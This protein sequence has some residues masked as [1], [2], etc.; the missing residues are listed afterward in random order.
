MS[1]G[2][3]SN[4]RIVLLGLGVI[5]SF[6]CVGARLV[7]LHVI[8]RDKLV[9][10]V[11]RARRQIT[12]ETARRGDIL[13]T[14]GDTLATSRSLIV[15]GVDPQALRKE[16]EAKWPKLAAMLNLS[17]ADLT[18][19]F[20]DKTRAA[21]PDDKS[22]EDRLIRWAKL[23]DDVEES[24]YDQINKLDI[25][26]VYGNRTYRRA[27]PHNSMA[28]HLI[29]FVNKEGQ[30]A[31]G[32]E[33][34]ADFY[35]RGQ[36]GWCETEKDGLRRE[37]AQFRSREVDATPGYSVVLSIDSAVQ[38]IVEQEIDAIV[39]KFNPAKVSVI[40]SDPNSGFILAMA[41]YPTF[42]LNEYNTL[43][44]D[45]MGNMRNLAITDILDP[46]STFKS[47]T[48]S[49]ALNE[50][51][52]TPATRFNCTL[53]SMDYKGTP[54]KFMPDDHHFDHPLTV[55]EIVSHSSNVG[56]AQLGMLLGEDRLY[57]YARSF[58]FG[59][60]SGFPFGGE[61]NGI[62]NSPDK[63]RG[64]DITHIPAG[65]SISATPLQIH[66]AMATIA[67]GG[68]LMRPQLIRQVR[69]ASGEVVYNFT[70]SVRRHVVTTRTAEQTA[71]LL[72]G[73]VSAEGTAPGAAIPNFE[74]AGKTGTSQ[75]LINGRYSDHDHVG[76]F[77]GFFPASR[78]RVVISV[79]VS[80]AKPPNGRIAYGSV[81]AAPSF[82]HIGE[83]LIQYLDIKP[84]TEQGSNLLV[85]DGGRR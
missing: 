3:A 78:P 38:H 66:Y 67:N 29:G 54:R 35:L 81:V 5:A 24:T 40:V 28:A 22:D 27:Y 72:E 8:D 6:G 47:V 9:S 56:A 76:S 11:D 83:Q 21:A 13:D 39:K 59:E 74:V 57:N 41:N 65:Y 19:V 10:Y 50:G 7:D 12:V 30:A 33:S 45:E 43:G 25:K 48:V 4:Y 55:A 49:A 42:N 18:K 26:G 58:G 71:R 37:M 44:K 23:S 75:M 2:F 79:I 46:G 34:Y 68:V 31:A 1:K 77:V 69:D 36:D 53:T 80:D 63:W 52:V 17:L 32:V 85:M 61:V 51:L 20:N 15:L 70:G 16:D 62:L 84:V 60:K 73:V 14:R 64:A 82:K